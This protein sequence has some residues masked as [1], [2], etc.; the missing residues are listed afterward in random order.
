MSLHP[1]LLHGSLVLDDSQRKEFVGTGEDGV[2]GDWRGQ[3][4]LWTQDEEFFYL[5]LGCSW[6]VLSHRTKLRM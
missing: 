6:R 5:S 1:E 4:C 3:T 2:H